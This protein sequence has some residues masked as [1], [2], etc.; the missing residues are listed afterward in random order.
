MARGPARRASRPAATVQRPPAEPVPAA[1]LVGL[2]AALVVLVV[3]AF[4]PAFSAEFLDFDD[5]KLFTLNHRWRGLGAEPLRWM[6]ATG[7]MGHYQPLTWLSFGIDHALHGL[8]GPAYPEAG[9]YHATSVALHA[10]SALAVLWL[11]W[12]LFAVALPR[13]DPTRRALA[14]AAAAAIWA[15]HP[16]RVESVVWLTERR[17][18]LSTLF[19]VLALDAWLAWAPVDTVH[20]PA[21]R[22]RLAAVAC[23]LVAL[24]GLLGG[25]DLSDPGGLGVASGPLL[26]AGVAA[27][28][29]SLVLVGRGSGRGV[30]LGLAAACL[31]LSLLA[32]AWGMVLPAILLLLDVWP[33]RRWST[34]RAPALLLEKLPLVV[35][36]LVFAR[37]AHWAQASMVGVMLTWD[38]HPLGARVAQ[39]F[40]GLAYYPA[41]TLAPTGLLPI[42]ELPKGMHLAQPRWLVAAAVVLVA[43]AAAVALRRRAPALLAACAAYVV[44]VAPVLGF[45]QSGPQLVA[46]RY[47]HL[48]ILPLVL[49]AA[50]GAALLSRT[51]GQAVA[52]LGAGLVAVSAAAT[53]HQATFWRSSASLWERA[54]AIA[55]ESPMIL[56]SLG[57]QRTKAADA[58]TD[59]ARAI[60][61]LRDAAA[62][63]QQAFARGDDPQ[64]LLN[65]SQVRTAMSLHDRANA[66]AHQR[67]ALELSQ[68]AVTLARE[69]NVLTPDYL[70]AWGTDLVNDGQLDAG[71]AQLRAYVAAA[72]DRLRGLV[73]LGGALTLAGRTAEALPFLDRACALEPQDPRG[74]V[75]LARAYDALG[76][77]ADALAAWR[78]A[79]G[80]GDRLAAERV[81]ALGGG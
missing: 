2:G 77:P 33:L 67:A 3:A 8:T 5:D 9:W 13:L 71:I 37:L 24:V 23:A 69:R 16:M 1:L 75:G 81:R 53:W 4:W 76:R 63:Y 62:L 38:A 80:L 31:L 36:A 6:L 59:P 40:Y 26:V 39:A 35:L 72:P 50:G 19:F 51:Q 68:R 55:P 17:D 22:A 28:I 70:L 7:H 61:L 66:R 54:Y 41:R 12:R 30:A 79:A 57:A 64:V 18:V 45:V 58:A 74:W 11:G 46:D 48:A 65:Q 32:K 20:A 27:W 42:Y 25:L 47:A 49:V 10:L 78:R 43:A 52:L 15:A 73:N 60:A 34:A 14:A 44:L 56:N 21:P 29:A